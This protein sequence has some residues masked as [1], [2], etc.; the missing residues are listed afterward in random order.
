MGPA[1]TKVLAGQL[2]GR[3]PDRMMELFWETNSMRMQPALIALALSLLASSAYAGWYET[4]GNDTGGLI[5]WS[6]AVKDAYREAA[7]DHCARYNKVAQI[8]SVHPWYG[9]F[10]G[11]AC[12][13]PPGYDP[14][15]AWYGP[16]VR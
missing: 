15:K 7:A 5:P 2:T 14:V 11:F 12:I 8:T 4:W 16:P 10:V 13:F 6:P 3:A 1:R 9:D